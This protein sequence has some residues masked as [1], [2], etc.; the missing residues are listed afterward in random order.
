MALRNPKD[1]PNDELLVQYCYVVQD[2]TR[3]KLRGEI[4]VLLEERQEALF[5]EILERLERC[6]SK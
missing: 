2:R 6:N 3:A 1:I 5:E 4:N